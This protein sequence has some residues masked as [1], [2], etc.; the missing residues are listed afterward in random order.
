LLQAH[1]PP[2][3]QK[4]FKIPETSEELSVIQDAEMFVCLVGF[5]LSVLKDCFIM[6]IMA[7]NDK[8]IIEIS[9]T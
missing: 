1:L 7:F 3:G 2:E 5:I 9:F 6:S 4:L 8:N